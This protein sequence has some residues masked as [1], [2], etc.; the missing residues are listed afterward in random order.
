MLFMVV[1]L[2]GA[3]SAKVTPLLQLLFTR[4]APYGLTILSMDRP[5][6]CDDVEVQAVTLLTGGLDRAWRGTAVTG[7]IVRWSS[8]DS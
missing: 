7:S 1:N 5:T 4:E 6:W 8:P 2:P 3:S